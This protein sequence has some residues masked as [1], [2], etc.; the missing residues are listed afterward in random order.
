MVAVVG[1]IGIH[2]IRRLGWDAVLLGAAVLITILL[3]NATVHRDN[4]INRN[5]AAAVKIGR[6]VCIQTQ[7]LIH[8]SRK[9]QTAAQQDAV[10]DIVD[11]Y[12][13]P[14]DQALFDLAK[15]HCRIPITE[16]RPQ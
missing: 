11:H 10:R 16:G 8:E 2:G 6:A 4:Q 9:N 12:V 5:T 14:I 3:W 15:Q 7:I 1:K 13:L